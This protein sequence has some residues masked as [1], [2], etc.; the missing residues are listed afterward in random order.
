MKI[1]KKF[2]TKLP[3][4]PLPIYK[5]VKIA[6]A[7]SKDK[8]KFDIFIGLDKKKVAQLKAYSS[9]KNDKELQ[10]NTGDRNRFGEGSYKDW[11]KK[12]RTPFVLIHRQSDALAAIVWFGPKPLGKKFPRLG[13]EEI[14]KIQD[15][16]HTISYRSYPEWRGKG[17][18]RKF[19]NF[20]ADLYMKKFPNIRIWTGIDTRNK[21]SKKLSLGLGFKTLEKLS[22]RKDHWLVMVKY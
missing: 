14:Y 9:D 18:M 12:I 13:K 19:V 2:N 3:S 11:Y 20:A 22:D 6:E 7:V 15:N 8:D 10:K 16:W 17:F 4:L 1:V 21:A 5:N